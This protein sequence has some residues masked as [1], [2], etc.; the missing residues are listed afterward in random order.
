MADEDKTKS[1][2]D[3][4]S[5]N[6]YDYL[7][8][9]SGKVGAITRKQNSVTKYFEKGKIEADKLKEFHASLTLKIKAFEEA[10]LKQ[11]EK[12][13]CKDDTETV[14]KYMRK[15]RKKYLTYMNKLEKQILEAENDSEK[16]SSESEDEEEDGYQSDSENNNTAK[17]LSAILK[18]QNVSK[19]PS[20]E[21]SIFNGEN[22]TE[23]NTFMLSFERLIEEHCLSDKDKYYYL[24]RYTAGDA[25]QL[26]SSCHNVDASKAFDD[27]KNL[28]KDRFGNEYVIAQKYLDR[29]YNWPVIK[30]EDSVGLNKFASYITTCCNMMKNMSA[31]NQLNSLRDIKEIMMKLPYDMRKSFRSI[32]DR[33]VCQNKVIDFKLFV[34]FVNTQSR[35]QNLPMIGQISDRQHKTERHVSTSK[36]AT[37]FTK[38]E[39]ND[40]YCHC[41]K[42]NNHCLNDCIF[43]LKKTVAERENFIK[44]KGL[45]FGCLNTG[46]RYKD[47]ETKMKCTKCDRMHPSCLHRMK[48]T[49]DDVRRSTNNDAS[50]KEIN[51]KTRDNERIVC[52]AVAVVIRNKLNG[53]KIEAFA[54]LDNYSTSS[55]MNAELIEKLDLL[56]EEKSLNVQTIEGDA[57]CI[58]VSVVK[59]LI[60][61]NLAG[62]SKNKLAK[63]YAKNKWPFTEKDSPSVRDIENITLDKN[64]PF[65]FI[66]GKI[67]ILIGMDNP[68]ILQPRETVKGKK[69]GPYAT[70]HILGWALNGPVKGSKLNLHCFRTV[71]RENDCDLH[72][73]IEE[74]F[75]KD[76]IST[77]ELSNK[78][79]IEDKKWLDFVESH[80]NLFIQGLGE[81]VPIRCRIR[82]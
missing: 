20:N 58:N 74:V 62:N 38:K 65:N 17:L 59:N 19:L 67:E 46:H 49:S 60:I 76:F 8:L 61:T 45:C 4:D 1:E 5:S 16:E 48:S 23:Y 50:N 80:T 79:S 43:F 3:Y 75:N 12:N 15:N 55:Y 10:C 14:E 18:N 54:A 22:I 57:Q 72:N 52:P 64:I 63:V 26:V 68:D 53:K 31:L 47:C 32:V 33:N 77:G 44:T 24:L 13:L 40:L 41:C 2:D 73:K 7:E 35:M 9:P 21:P 69:N 34:D 28:L 71:V 6:E 66:S 37:F 11:K 70:R 39:N 27:A 25:N 56:S 51:M 42:K 78:Y 81:K 82:Q 36:H 29:L 30:S